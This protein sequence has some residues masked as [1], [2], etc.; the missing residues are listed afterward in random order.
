MAINIL[1]QLIAFLNIDCNLVNCF[2]YQSDLHALFFVFFFP[3][4][5]LILFIYVLSRSLAEKLAGGQQ[6]HKGLFLLL[7]VAF[8]IYIILQKWFTIFVGMTTTYFFGVIIFMGFT[9][10]FLR[11]VFG[12]GNGGGGGGGDRH[13]GA[14]SGPGGRGRR[15][16]VLTPFIGDTEINPWNIMADRKLIDDEKR[17]LEAE[18][19]ELE[20][21][22]SSRKGENLEHI[23]SQIGKINAR[24]G[25]LD[26]IK[27]NFKRLT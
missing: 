12:R 23:H 25:E 6:T 24:I 2:N 26:H 9:V 16:N 21:Y 18:K 5:M 10:F 7:S 4:V 8:Y 17:K 1:E 11:H 22:A 14:F 15:R 13:G 19:K 20:D 3:T 27:K